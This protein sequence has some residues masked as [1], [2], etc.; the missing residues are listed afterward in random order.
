MIG[1]SGLAAWILMS[2][3]PAVNAGVSINIGVPVPAPPPVVVVAPAP[4]AV[5]VQIGV[6]DSYVWDGYEYVGLVGTQYYYLGPGDVWLTL[7]ATRLARFQTWQHGHPDWRTHAIRNVN[8]R[9]DA[10]G[11]DQPARGH[12]QPSHDSVKGHDHDGH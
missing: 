4:P 12:D 3:A 10:K 2:T 8:Y 1:M 5:T 7:D 11:H 9:H 6:P